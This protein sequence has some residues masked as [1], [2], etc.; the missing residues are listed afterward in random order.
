MIY[1]DRIEKILEEAKEEENNNPIKVIE[2]LMDT[3]ERSPYF[4][5]KFL[6]L[7]EE[8]FP[9]HINKNI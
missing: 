9:K 3:I 7:V 8:R 6:T 1:L 4:K 5:H 2:S